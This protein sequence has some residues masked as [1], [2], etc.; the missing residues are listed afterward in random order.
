MKPVV[1]IALAVAFAAGPVYAACTY[2]KAP[3]QLPDGN[4]ATMEE[5]VAGKKAVESYNKEMEAYLSCIKLE[6]E[7]A[8]SKDAD[9]LSEDQKKE[10]EKM[11]V[12]KHNAAIDELEAVAARFNEQVRA[13]K[14][15]SKKS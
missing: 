13:Y 7:G 1:S 9:E 8:M 10:M 14:A 3:D 5:M 11:Q 6:H 2:P 15:K 4:T 12:Q